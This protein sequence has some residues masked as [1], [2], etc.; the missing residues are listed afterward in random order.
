MTPELLADMEQQVRAGRCRYVNT[1]L[2]PPGGEDEEPIGAFSRALRK[3]GEDYQRLCAHLGA[4]RVLLENVPWESRPGFP[5]P[6]V[7]ADPQ[8]L[9]AVLERWGGWLLLDLAHVQIAAAQLEHDP[10]EYLEQMPT[11]L[12]RELHV[13]GVGPDATGRVRDSMPM[14]DRD[15]ELCTF[16]LDRVAD[17]TWARPW[18]V[19][20]E[21]GGVGPHFAW[22]SD[23]QVL[24]EQLPRLERL[25][26]D[27]SL[28]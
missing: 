5:F 4:E 24:A 7:A 9:T 19:T 14:T 11:R 18:V 10:F 17:G 23:E 6:P 2:G 25:L 20:F 28:R 13:T 15:W 16:A 27:R 12:L 22:R 26:R 3:V 8:L 21:Y 1:H